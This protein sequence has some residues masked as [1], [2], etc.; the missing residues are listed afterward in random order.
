[1]RKCSNNQKEEWREHP[2]E[3]LIF[4]DLK[5]V[6]GD[7]HPYDAVEGKDEDG[8]RRAIAGLDRS[9]GQIDKREKTEEK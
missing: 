4:T 1:M 3:T 7:E 2:S 8:C 6:P 5:H 9:N